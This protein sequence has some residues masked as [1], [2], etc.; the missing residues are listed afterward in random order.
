MSSKIGIAAAAVA[1]AVFAFAPGA[2]LAASK[3][4]QYHDNTQCLGGGCTGQ[5]PDRTFNDPRNIGVGSY[6]RTTKKKHTQH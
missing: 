2:S 1:L 6:K 4:S 5:N 3:K